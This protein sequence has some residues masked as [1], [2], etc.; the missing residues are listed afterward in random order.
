MIDLNSDLGEHY[1]VYHLGEDERIMP[2]IT[3]ANIACGYHAGDADVMDRTVKL[4]K[5]YGVK[6]GAHPGYEDLKGFGRR[7][8]PMSIDAMVRMIVYQVGALQGICDINE[9]P[10]V[11]VKPHGAL[12]NYLADHYEAAIEVAKAI[13]NMR[14][15]Y[16]LYGLSGSEM[17]RAANAIELPFY[18]EVFS[19]RNY[20]DNGKLLDRQLKNA[21]IEDVD[22]AVGRM[23]KLIETGH[24]ESSSGK[25]IHLDADTICLHGDGSHAIQLAEKLYHSLSVR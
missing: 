25:R 14:K 19:D 2:Y 20:S 16:I 23:K 17:Q 9:V 1:G 18:A 3:S 10:L 21:L 22:I 5:K 6:V 4:C 12:Y 11:H 15:G 7:H 13:K 8:I 24:I